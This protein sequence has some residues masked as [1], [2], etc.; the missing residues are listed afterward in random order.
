MAGI[1][2]T[3]SGVGTE[4]SGLM[5]DVGRL[6]D[7][8]KSPRGTTGAF[9]DRGMPSLSATSAEFTRLKTRMASGSGTVGL[10]MKNGLM[11]RASGV[12]ASVDSVRSLLTTGEG[13]FGRF[14][15]D[16]TLAPTIKGIIAEL[17]SLR[18]LA[19]DPAGSL[20]RA[21]GDSTLVTEVARARA[22]L[23]ALVKDIKRHPLRYIAF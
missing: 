19:T 11:A 10:A 4:V 5:T 22:E 7:A 1:T 14:R 13:T 18:S 9:V 6:V 12:M 16:S 23:Q 17:D 3:L 8:V 21:R 15:R 2:A 20:G